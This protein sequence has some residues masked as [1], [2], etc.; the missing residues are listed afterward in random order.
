[1]TSRCYDEELAWGLA[2][3]FSLRTLRKGVGCKAGSSGNGEGRKRR[4]N[5]VGRRN[6]QSQ[7]DGGAG[8]PAFSKSMYLTARG[9]LVKFSDLQLVFCSPAQAVDC[10]QR[11]D[12]GT[13]LGVGFN[14][15]SRH[16]H[17]YWENLGQSGFYPHLNC[18]K[19]FRKK[20]SLLL[21]ISRNEGMLAAAG[22]FFQQFIYLSL[23]SETCMHTYVLPG[24][25]CF[26]V[27]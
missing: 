9:K 8:L 24:I 10:S 14:S 5:A 17:V 15:L 23:P 3:S 4:G 13:Y 16:P 1:M 22:M 19:L 11:A 21:K 27:L 2:R 12:G 6:W 26:P 18:I 25:L 20:S 7:W